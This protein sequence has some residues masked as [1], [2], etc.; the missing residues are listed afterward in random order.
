MMNLCL[1]PELEY[2]IIEYII[3][4]TARHHGIPRRGAFSILTALVPQATT[5]WAHVT[6]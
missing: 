1:M 4:G 5:A 2:T 6:R 3:I